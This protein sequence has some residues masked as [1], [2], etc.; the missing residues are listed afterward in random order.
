MLP[1]PFPVWRWLVLPFVLMLAAACTSSPSREE[2]AR[3]LLERKRLVE[4]V[5]ASPAT[6]MFL[7]QMDEVAFRNACIR[8]IAK[9]LTDEELADAL[10][11]SRSELGAKEALFQEQIVRTSLFGQFP[12]EGDVA[13]AR[14]NLARELVAADPMADS[15]AERVR[16]GVARS[17][18][19]AFTEDE[20][21]QLLA[22]AREPL[23]VSVQRKWPQ[24]VSRAFQE[25]AQSGQKA[26]R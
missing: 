25:L 6:A 16:T 11:F 21:I 3:E 5:R 20:L 22:R 7:G 26:K 14:L 2:Q 4:I 24:I 18:A 19:V 8:G 17:A 13:P 12:A 1:R 23:A 15:M 10:G 9:G